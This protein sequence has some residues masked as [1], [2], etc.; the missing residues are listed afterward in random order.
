MEKTKIVQ[1]G[2]GFG[3]VFFLVLFV[4]KVT[5]PLATLSWWWVTAPLWGPLALVA[6]LFVV[7]IPAFMLREWVRS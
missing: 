3:P 5:G 1:R 2:L 4:L 7:L 6:A